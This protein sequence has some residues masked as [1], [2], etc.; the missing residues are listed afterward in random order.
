[1]LFVGSAIL[2]AWGIAHVAIP[3]KAIVRGFG[4]IST[5]NKRILL[6]EWLMEGVLLV[7]VGLLVTAVRAFAPEGETT[8][9]VVYRAS[10]II[11]IIMAGISLLTGA[12][13]KIGPM[14]LCPPIFGAVAVLYWLATVI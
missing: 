8:P 13:T 4:P 14:R 6:M 3:T 1:M 2:V 11:L 9:I 12:R 7:F 10:A 5:D